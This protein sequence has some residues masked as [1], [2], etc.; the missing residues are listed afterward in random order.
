VS[1]QIVCHEVL[2]LLTG[3]LEGALPADTREAVEAHLS[4]CDGCTRMLAQV[5]RTI[6]LTGMLTEEQVTPTQRATLLDAFRDWAS[7]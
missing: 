4:S 3:Y 6:E 1:E 2:E 5:R 7:G